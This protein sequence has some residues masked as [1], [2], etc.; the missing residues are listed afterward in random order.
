MEKLSEFT[1]KEF[2]H[3]NKNNINYYLRNYKVSDS[4][5]MQYI[6]VLDI[7]ELCYYQDISEKIAE[8][9]CN[10]LDWNIINERFFDKKTNTSEDIINKYKFLIKKLAY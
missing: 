9:F 6:M 5:I 10:I 1:E 2:K 4:V 8:K 7:N 3:V